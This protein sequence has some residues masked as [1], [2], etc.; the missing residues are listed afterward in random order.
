MAKRAVYDR[1]N[2]VEHLMREGDL[3]YAQATK[4][5]NVVCSVFG[6]AVVNGARI[7]IGRVGAIVPHWRPPRD[8]R[9]HFTRRG[10]KV[11]RGTERTFF[12]DGRYV[13][14]FNVYRRFLKTRQLRWVLDMP[15][16]VGS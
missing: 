5:F 13:F 6:E 3:T 14:K 8:V 10:K 11:R 16:S 1:R 7:N 15:V 2:F 9:M 4:I 12:M